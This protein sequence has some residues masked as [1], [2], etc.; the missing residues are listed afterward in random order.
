LFRLIH[1]HRFRWHGNL[2]ATNFVEAK[3]VETGALILLALTG[4]SHTGTDGKDARNIAAT[5]SLH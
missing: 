1:T 2:P 5:K 3:P 4:G